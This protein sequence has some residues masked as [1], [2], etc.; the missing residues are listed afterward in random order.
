[1][2]CYKFIPHPHFERLDMLKT[3]QQPKKIFIDS[4]WDWNCRGVKEEWILTILDKIKECPQHTFQILSKRPQKYSRFSYPENVWLGTSIA[5]NADTHRI[6]RLLQTNSENIKFVSIEPIH[7]KIDCDFSGLDWIIVG[8]ETGNRKDKVIA[9][10]GWIKSVVRDARELG[11]PVFIKNNAKRNKTIREFPDK[12]KKEV[13]KME[14]MEQCLS[15]ANDVRVCVL[16]YQI[17]E[18]ARAGGMSEERQRELY[19]EI[20]THYS[21]LRIDAT[22]PFFQDLFKIYN[23]SERN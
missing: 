22:E 1:M 6:D 12:L 8:A 13:T 7:E 15:L 23:I 5:T 2:L 10:K 14:I 21:E 9:K 16:I 17:L 4:M 19:D 20:L 3:T 11:I 18:V